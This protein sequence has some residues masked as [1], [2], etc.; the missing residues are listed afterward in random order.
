MLP[1]VLLIKKKMD[2]MTTLGDGRKKDHGSNF[3]R[4]KKFLSSSQ[5]TLTFLFNRNRGLCLEEKVSGWDVKVTTD[6]I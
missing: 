6:F 3:S 5:S 2:V 4:G 1:R